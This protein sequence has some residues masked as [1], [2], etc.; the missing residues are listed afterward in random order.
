MNEDLRFFSASDLL[1]CYDLFR[2]RKL[3]DPAEPEPVLSQ[4]QK[5]VK[6]LK[7]LSERHIYRWDPHFRY[8]ARVVCCHVVASLALYYLVMLWISYGYYISKFDKNSTDLFNALINLVLGTATDIEVTFDLFTSTIEVTHNFTG[9]TVTAIFAYIICTIQSLLGFKSVKYSLLKFYEGKHDSIGKPSSNVRA[10]IGNT[11]FAGFVVGYLLNGFVF[12]WAMLY[13]IFL[14][15]YLIIDQNLWDEVRWLVLK[16]LPVFITLLLKKIF[17]LVAAKFFF[18][19][20]RGALL[21]LDNFRFYSIFV[22]TMFFF[23]CVIGGI[24]ALVRL[25]FG[26]I[27]GLLFMPRIG[28]SCLGKLSKNIC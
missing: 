8:S 20:E 17:N 6:K 16:L 27:G 3:V 12:I 23:D 19:Q 28:Y 24:S 1:Y 22:Y 21:A 7:E 13:I 9:W 14:V 18:L 25:V 2:K 10:S 15:A 5:I 11:T 26:L 4:K